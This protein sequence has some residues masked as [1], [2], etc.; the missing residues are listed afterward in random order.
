MSRDDL[1]FWLSLIWFLGLCGAAVWA[2]LAM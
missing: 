1:F 2:F